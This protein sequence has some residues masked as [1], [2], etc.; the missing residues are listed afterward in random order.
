MRGSQVDRDIGTV[1]KRSIP[2]G[3]GQPAQ[4]MDIRHN[5]TVYPRGCGAAGTPKP[6]ARGRKGLSPRVRGSPAGQNLRC[7]VSRSIPAGAGQPGMRPFYPKLAKVYPRGCGAASGDGRPSPQPPGLSPRVRGSLLWH[8][9]HLSCFRSIPA[10]AG[11]AISISDKERDP[12]GL[13]P[14]VRGSQFH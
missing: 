7:G 2:A 4:V 13:S 12:L 3:A 9:V 6:P 5:L 11:P 8:S 1:G 10:G 14:R